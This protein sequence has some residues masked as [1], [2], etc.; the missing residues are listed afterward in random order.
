MVTIFKVVEKVDVCVFPLKII[1]N[2]FYEDFLY[3]ILK[4]SYLE[5]K[6]NESLINL[7]RAIFLFLLQF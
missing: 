1:Y 4:S 6:R 2:K 7:T 3:V 5:E